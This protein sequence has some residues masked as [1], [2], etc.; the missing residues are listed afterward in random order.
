MA[1]L[2][3]V[4]AMAGGSV[5]TVSNVVN[6][7]VFVRPET[8]ERVDRAI[9]TLGYRPNLAARSLRAGRTGVIGLGV[10]ELKFS[11]FAELADAVLEEAKARGYVVLIQ[12]TG[13]IREAE[14][15]ML[16]RTRTPMLDGLIFSPLGLLSSDV[17]LLDVDYP[18]VLLGERIF[19]GPTDHV[20]MDNVGGAYEATAHLL[21]SGRRRIA[22]IGAHSGSQVDSATLRLDGYRRALA[23]HA[24]VQESA[25]VVVRQGWH[26]VDGAEAT[27]ELLRRGVLFDGIFALNDELALGALRALAEA[28]LN[29]PGDVA[30]VG[31]DN[32]LE[33]QFT[34]PNL[35]S[36]DPQR[37]EIARFAVEALTRRIG[38]GG[39]AGEPAR[40]VEVPARLIVRE[41]APA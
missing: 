31:F 29:V 3:D 36:V 16:R 4:A 38:V 30:V 5:K 33:G 6:G 39:G 19:G 34:M 8:R 25:L 14:V 18:L 12:Q 2:K 13:G 41:S 28:G 11:Y 24:A 32:V 37:S 26:R 40:R 15:D 35:T 10:P 21:R 9:V 23:D 1:T 7:Q 20:V 17:G 27:R 22:V